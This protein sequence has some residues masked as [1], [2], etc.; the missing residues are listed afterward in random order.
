M[1]MIKE[2][3]TKELSK[4]KKEEI[5]IQFLDEFVIDRNKK[6]DREREV[7]IEKVKFYTDGKDVVLENTIV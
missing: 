4:E 7:L 6:E 5:F 1:E 2:K 3:H